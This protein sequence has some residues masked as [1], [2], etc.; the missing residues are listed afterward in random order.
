MRGEEWG[1]A[2]EREGRVSAALVDER[3]VGWVAA[4]LDER[5]E[6]WVAAREDSVEGRVSVPRLW[7]WI[8]CVSHA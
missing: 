7:I 4:L 2:R 3:G 8:S 5:G 1:A 6:E